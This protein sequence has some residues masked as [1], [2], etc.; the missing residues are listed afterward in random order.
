MLRAFF[1]SA[2][3]RQNTQSATTQMNT[4]NVT[5]PYK[6]LGQWVFD[7][8]RV[9]LLH[10]PFVAGADTWIDRVVAG[11]PDAEQGF[12]LIFSSMPFPGASIPARGARKAAET[13]IIPLISIWRDGCVRLFFVI[14]PKHQRVFSLR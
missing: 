3:R 13:G 2:E 12:T 11:I 6:H 9:G 14:S 10:E 8:P 5:S 7:D 4:I 1:Y